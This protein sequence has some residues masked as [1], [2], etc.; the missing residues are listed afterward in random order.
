MS[1]REENPYKEL[2]EQFG[3]EYSDINLPKKT[4]QDLEAFK[5]EVLN[6]K[7]HMA[8]GDAFG[9]AY[10]GRKFAAV[11]QERKLEIRKQVK[12]PALRTISFSRWKSGHPL[13][14]YI[15]ALNHTVSSFSDLILLREENLSEEKLKE[16]GSLQSIVQGALIQCGM[17]STDVNA[18]SRMSR[19]YYEGELP[20]C[21]KNGVINEID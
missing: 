17:G 1:L 5:Y 13:H 21:R 2:R 3:Y 14:Y 16:S 6:I 20:T 7:I 11:Y 8:Y 19:L 9:L 12:L 15:K 10:D 18:L 4:I